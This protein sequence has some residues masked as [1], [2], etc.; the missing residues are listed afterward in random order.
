MQ[1]GIRASRDLTVR[2][3][4]MSGVVD[5]VPMR[6]G[7]LRLSGSPID[8][9]RL[10]AA[11]DQGPLVGDARHTAGHAPHPNPGLR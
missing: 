8:S 10:H 9:R 2:R 5:A 3:R 6:C 4:R 11:N 7:P 1:A